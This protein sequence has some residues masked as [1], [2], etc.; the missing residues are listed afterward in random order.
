MKQNPIFPCNFSYLR[1]RLNSTDLR[2]CMNDRDQY[3]FV[4]YCFSDFLGIYQSML[5]DP[6]IRY[7]KPLFLKETGGVQDRVVLDL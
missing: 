6:E 5:I 4:V 7:D 2:T 1:D 3:S